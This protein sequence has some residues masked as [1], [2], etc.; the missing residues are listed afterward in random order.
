MMPHPFIKKRPDHDQR[1]PLYA[2]LHSRKHYVQTPEFLGSRQCL[3]TPLLLAIAAAATLPL[4]SY[5][6]GGYNGV[7]PIISV[8]ALLFGMVHITDSHPVKADKLDWGMALMLSA[9]FLIPSQQLIWFIALAASLWLFLR[10][11][12]DTLAQQSALLL[13]ST[14]LLNVCVVYALKVFAGPVLSM[15]AALITW[16]VQWTTGEGH[17]LGNVI[18][19]PAEHELLILR[20]C[21]SIK[22]FADALMAW[23]IVARFRGLV[24][25]QREF[26]MLIALCMSLS[27]LNIIR[28]YTM[29]ID[30][31]WHTW[32]HT[33]TGLQVFQLAS[34]SIVFGFI[35]MGLNYVKSH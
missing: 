10:Q 29:V 22:L 4:F 20:G 19:G 12:M 33:E 30:P 32:W 26:A 21:S 3:F 18:F 27:S 15:D 16:V 5:H 11:D 24:P 1:H 31:W 35:A 13:A 28:L 14:A 34:I 2:F 9:L 23:F 17:R 6:P 7:S 8:A 25:S